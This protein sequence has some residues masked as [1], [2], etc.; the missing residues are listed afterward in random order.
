MLKTMLTPV[1]RIDRG[2]WGTHIVNDLNRVVQSR[3]TG[4]GISTLLR[5]STGPRVR[6]EA[7]REHEARVRVV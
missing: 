7:D 5:S 6:L 2:I 3:H 4:N 1:A